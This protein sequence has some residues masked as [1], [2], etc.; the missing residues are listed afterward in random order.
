MKLLTTLLTTIILVVCT[1]AQEAASAA[2][3]SPAFDKMKSLVGEW[4][5]KALE[6]GKEIPT[7]TSF[8]LVSDGSALLSDLNP[9]TA[10]EM[11]TMFHMDNSDFLATHYCS[12][13]NQPRFRAVAGSD[14]NVILFEF[15]DATNLA[16]PDAPHMDH[17]KFTIIDADH[18]IE[19][20]SYLDNGKIATGRFDF[21][22]K[23]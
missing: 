14:P 23:K 2:H 19:E 3:P 21:R 12:A 4:K 1:S 7:S 11:V 17:V 9:G 15:K 22:R 13:H 6:G 18:H 8:K 16:T 10:D 20:W 5:G